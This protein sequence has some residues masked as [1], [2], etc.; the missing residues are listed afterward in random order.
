MSGGVAEG[1]ALGKELLLPCA[2][3]CRGSGPRQ[4]VF[5]EGC[6][7]P[8]V[9]PS[10]KTLCRVPDYLPSVKGQ[11]IG[12]DALSGSVVK[13]LPSSSH[14]LYR[15]FFL[16]FQIINTMYDITLLLLEIMSD[17]MHT[18]CHATARGVE[19]LFLSPIFIQ[20]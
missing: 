5:A 11:A 19:G 16:I 6:S 1:L 18:E 2:C 10:A 14:Q 8:R 17:F 4:R 13:S 7:L 9:R 20:T 3:L 15:V 12:K